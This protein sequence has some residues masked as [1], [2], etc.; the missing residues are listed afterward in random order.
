MI[1]TALIS[2]LGVLLVSVATIL[3]S[4]TL[5]PDDFNDMLA[6][7]IQ[8]VWSWDWLFPVSALLAVLGAI[9]TFITAEF[10]WRG[11]RYLVQLFRGN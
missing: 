6:D 7:L 9:I 10:A 4:G 8:Y 3:P 1:I 11:G 5:L 2:I